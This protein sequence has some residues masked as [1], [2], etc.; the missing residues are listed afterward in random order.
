MPELCFALFVKLILFQWHNPST[1]IEMCH[2]V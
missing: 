1:M 2:M